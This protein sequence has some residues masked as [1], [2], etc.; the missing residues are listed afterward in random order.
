MVLLLAPLILTG[1]ACAGNQEPSQAPVI[2][3]RPATIKQSPTTTAWETPGYWASKADSRSADVWGELDRNALHVQVASAIVV[4][5]NG[6]QLY[7][8]NATMVT[9]IASVTKLMT[10]MIVLDTGVSLD[11]RI[12]IVDQDRDRLRNSRSRL[13]IGEARLSRADLMRA[14]LVSSDNRAAHALGRTTYRGGMP[15]FIKAMNRKARALGMRNTY[16]ADC[17]GLDARNRSTAEDLVKMVRAAARYSFIRQ[18]AATGE[19]MLYPFSGRPPLTYRNTNPLVRDPDWT[20]EVSKTGFI[21][22]AGRC[23]V[24]QTVINDRRVYIVLLRGS[25]RMT[26][27]G[28]S[29]RIRD[30]LL[31]ATQTVSR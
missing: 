15:E 3:N 27:F 9:P 31:T 11:R 28:D 12:T 25:G 16:F 23:L 22:E 1:A 4:D 10:A 7:A 26:P 21:N 29:K 13:R 6:R 19:M 5:E 8:K 24:M 18:A 20:I 30:W 2:S 14:A 17:S